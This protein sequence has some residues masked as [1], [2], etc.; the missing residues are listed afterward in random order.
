MLKTGKW[1]GI[2]AL[3]D[4]LIH[5]S[6]KHSQHR[7]SVAQ[8]LLSDIPVLHRET[9]DFHQRMW[10]VMLSILCPYR[11]PAGWSM[12]ENWISNAP[13]KQERECVLKPMLKILERKPGSISCLL[14]LLGKAGVFWSPSD[15]CMRMLLLKSKLV[16]SGSAVLSLGPRTFLSL[17]LLV[18]HLTERRSATDDVKLI[19]LVFKV[20]GFLYPSPN[21]LKAIQIRSSFW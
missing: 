5:N 6:E 2:A 13:K 12:L 21:P 18:R 20:S 9:D 8:H 16:S 4:V 17:G 14:T 19:H 1:L 11:P 3:P 7:H 10:S 15:F